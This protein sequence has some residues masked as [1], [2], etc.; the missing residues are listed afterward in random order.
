M[1]EQERFEREKVLLEAQAAESFEAGKAL[2][3]A[4]F[5]VGKLEGK[6]EGKQ[7]LMEWLKDRCEQHGYYRNGPRLSCPACLEHIKRE[8]GMEE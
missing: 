5:E 1:T 4:A 8:L 3:S 6:L 7:E 2:S